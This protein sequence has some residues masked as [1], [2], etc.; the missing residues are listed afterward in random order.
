MKEKLGSKVTE[1][2]IILE[3]KMKMNK[4]IAF[5]SVFVIAVTSL[6]VTSRAIS[7]ESREQ[8]D[9]LELEDVETPMGMTAEEH[10][11]MESTCSGDVDEEVQPSTGTKHS[12]YRKTLKT[13]MSENPNQTVLSVK[14][15]GKAYRT[16]TL[17]TMAVTDYCALSMSK[18]T[19]GKERLSLKKANKKVTE[20][21]RFLSSGM[22]VD[23]YME[24]MNYMWQDRTCYEEDYEVTEFDISEKLTYEKYVEVLKNLSRVEGVNL[25]KIGESELGRDMY[26]IEIDVP[27]EEDKEVVML[28]GNVHTREMAGGNIIIKQLYDLV[29]SYAEG[30]D[31]VKILRNYKIAA[32]PICSLDAREGMIDNPDGWTGSGM[33][34]P[35]KLWKA[36]A[37]GTDL[38]RNFPGLVYTTLAKGQTKSDWVPTKAGYMSYY[39]DYAG[40]ASETK[41]LMKWFYHYIVVENARMYIDYHQQGRVIYGGKIWLSDEMDNNC[42]SLVKKVQK[43]LSPNRAAYGQY[44]SSSN[45]NPFRGSGTSMTDFAL[46]CAVGAKYSSEYGIF[47][48]TDDEGEHT[49]LELKNLEGYK[50]QV[51]RSD[52][53]E[54]CIEIGSGESYLGYSDTARKNYAK[55]YKN[56]HFDEMLW[57]L[58]GE[59]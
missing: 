10:E 49:I 59:K 7:T 17:S 57:S 26:A 47:V 31:A 56:Y 34:S 52:F 50:N 55:E 48:M 3:E 18:A 11:D 54:I 40:C 37:D 30:G 9:V 5:I 33:E 8:Y 36:L 38:N 43:I 45:E 32:V 16:E 58:L 29:N 46:T 51:T 24:A 20:Y 6:F 42:R 39:G 41:A 44:E 23:E 28:T 12:R 4:F 13:Y 53:A 2:Y 27:S 21:G 15:A 35:S 25:Y 1:D 19:L 14:S 22:P